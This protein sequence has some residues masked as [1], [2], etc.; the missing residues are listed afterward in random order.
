M[1]SCHSSE[2]V[3]RSL[4][5]S[6]P[7]PCHSGT[8]PKDEDFCQHPTLGWSSGHLVTPCQCRSL[9]HLK[10]KDHCNKRDFWENLKK[11]HC[12]C[13]AD[14]AVF[15]HQSAVFL[16]QFAAFL[17][18]FAGKLETA[19]GGGCRK[20]ANGWRKSCNTVSDKLQF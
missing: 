11:L 6:I 2:C 3:C 17:H 9:R 19:A 10:V 1:S 12:S 4:I 8:P 14:V 20:T 13:P 5:L 15:L 18:Q 16:H 7:N